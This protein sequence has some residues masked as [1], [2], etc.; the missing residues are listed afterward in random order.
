MQIP[1]DRDVQN[2]IEESCKQGW[3]VHSMGQKGNGGW[4]VLFQREVTY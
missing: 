4:F 2:Y 3:A 1:S